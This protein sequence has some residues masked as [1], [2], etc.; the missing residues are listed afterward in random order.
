MKEFRPK[1]NAAAIAKLKMQ[2][3]YKR[4][5]LRIIYFNIWPPRGQ[6][7]GENVVNRNSDFNINLNWTCVWYIK[8]IN[9]ILVSEVKW[10]VVIERDVIWWF[11]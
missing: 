1:R 2:E 6:I 11:M 7:G 9:N 10:T 5:K 3:Y 4:R 8:I